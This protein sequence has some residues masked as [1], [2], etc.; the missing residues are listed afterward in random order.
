MISCSSLSIHGPAGSA[1]RQDKGFRLSQSKPGRDHPALFAQR[2]DLEDVDRTFPQGN[3]DRVRIVHRCRGTMS[4]YDLFVV[5]RDRAFDHVAKNHVA[6][7]LPGFGVHETT[8][9]RA[10]A[11]I[12]RN[13]EESP[14]DDLCQNFFAVHRLYP[15][16]LVVARPRRTW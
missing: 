7:C 6:T 5:S 16:N 11:A 1:C 13:R 4:N 9:F 10:T 15:P 14:G 2:L 12:L 8:R 3:D